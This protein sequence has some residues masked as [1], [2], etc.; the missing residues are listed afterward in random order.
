M[1]RTAMRVQLTIEVDN[2]I[3]GDDRVSPSLKRFEDN[4]RGLQLVADRR[5]TDPAEELT[6]LNS[7]F[8]AHAGY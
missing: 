3:E 7:E 1:A 4:R 6:W 8:G 2:G 5:Q